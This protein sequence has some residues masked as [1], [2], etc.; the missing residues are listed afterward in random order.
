MVFPSSRWNFLK[1]LSDSLEREYDSLQ[2]G[3]WNAVS[4]CQKIDVVEVGHKV[5]GSARSA[6]AIAN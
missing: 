6:R 1:V 5:M 3:V 2:S 4:H